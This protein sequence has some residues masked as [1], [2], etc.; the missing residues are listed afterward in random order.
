MNIDQMRRLYG[1]YWRHDILDFHYLINCYFPTKELY[2]KLQK[3]LPVLCDHYPSGQRVVAGLLSKWN[4]AEY[5]NEEN[6]VVANG[7]SE[8]IRFMNLLVTKATVAVPT[9]NE[10][11]RLPKEKINLFYADE[12]KNFK[13][14]VDK[15]IESVRKSKSDFVM[16]NNPNNP[17]GNIFTRDEIKKLLETGVKVVVDEA[18]I[19][20]SK[21]HSVQDMVAEY[22][23]L[24]VVTTCTKSM[25]L[26]GLRLGYMLTANKEIKEKM[27]EMIPI[28]NVNS[29]AE[30]F[31]ELF[32]DFKDDYWKAIEKTIEDRDHLL[33]ELKKISYLEPFESHANFIFCRTSISAR[34]IAEHLFDKHRIMVKD[35]LNQSGLKSD[36]YIRVGTLTRKDNEKL[37]KG[38]KEIR[39]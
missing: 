38:L 7:S 13:V 29:I 4:D 15:L 35:G 8:L 32:P 19:D 1:G 14:D 12:K 16:L 10:Y 17:V 22:D 20:F 30:R 18:F 24:I 31:I 39:E 9:F 37:V 27:R 21:E 34:K 5:F 11:V 28:W 23:N 25:G 33:S 3:E 36:S 26:S 6:L 2:A